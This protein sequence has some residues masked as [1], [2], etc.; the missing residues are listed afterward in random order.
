[1]KINKIIN[2]VNIISKL[3][4]KD[5]CPWD[6]ELDLKSLSKLTLE[7]CYELIDSIEENDPTKIV[8]E[9]SD[10][11]THLLFYVN[12]GESNKMFDIDDVIDNAHKKLISRHPHVFDKENFGILGSAE[13]VKDNWD[14]IKYKEVSESLLDNFDFFAPSSI[15]ATRII[16]KLIAKKIILEDKPLDINFDIFKFYYLL[17]QNEKDPESLLRKKLVKI[18]KKIILEEKRLGTNLEN[19][20]KE[21][22]INILFEY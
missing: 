11:L 20:D 15:L 3:S 7:E 12:I 2:L 17:I 21:K 14:S 19:F 22:I 9:L 8:D 16:K 18:K 6:K 13:E 1:M 10:L 4:S 5:G